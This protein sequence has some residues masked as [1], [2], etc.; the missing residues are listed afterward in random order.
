[1]PYNIK[2]ILVL[3]VA[4]SLVNIGK[5]IHKAKIGNP[6]KIGLLLKDC[7]FLHIIHLANI[8]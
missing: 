5:N 8:L 1:M 3:L 2:A 4:A 6:I 7:F